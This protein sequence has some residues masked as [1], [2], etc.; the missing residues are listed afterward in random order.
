MRDEAILN[1]HSTVVSINASIEAF[2]KDGELVTLDEAKIS[3]EIA[4][5]QAE[6]DAQDY[7]RKRFEAYANIT[8]QLDMLYWDQKNGTTT[9]QDHVTEIKNKHPKS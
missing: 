5:L 7:S 6:Y 8:D 4:R 3:T 9:W 2:D 1:T